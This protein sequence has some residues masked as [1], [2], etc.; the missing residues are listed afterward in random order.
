MSA[1]SFSRFVHT[2]HGSWVG[3]RESEILRREKVKAVWESFLEGDF[4]REH[5]FTSGN[6]SAPSLHAMACFKVTGGAPA[7]FF[8][9]YRSG[10]TAS[11]RSVLRGDEWVLSHSWLTAQETP[12]VAEIRLRLLSDDKY[13]Q[14]VYEMDERGGSRLLSRAILVRE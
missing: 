10:Q 12:E 2:L 9:V 13:S 4:L 1:I 8:A 7:E 6:E 5:W 3:E 14:E 11:G